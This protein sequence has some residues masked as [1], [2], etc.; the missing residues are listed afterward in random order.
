MRSKGYSLR[1]DCLLYAEKPFNRILALASISGKGVETVSKSRDTL[2]SLLWSSKFL[3]SFFLFFQISNSAAQNPYLALPVVLGSSGSWNSLSFANISYTIGEPSIKTI[4]GNTRIFSQ[5]FHQPDPGS[6][7]EICAVYIPNAFTPFNGHVNDTFLIPSVHNVKAEAMFYTSTQ[8]ARKNNWTIESVPYHQSY[9]SPV[10]VGQVMSYEDTD[11]SVF[12]SN[13]GNQRSVPTAAAMG[14]GKHVAE[15]GSI[16]RMDETLG[17]VVLE[18][19]TGTAVDGEQFYA[20]RTAQMVAGIDQANAIN[21]YPQFVNQLSGINCGVC[22][23]SGMFDNDGSWATFYNQNNHFVNK[24]ARF[25]LLEDQI[26]DAERAHRPEQVSYVLFGTI[27]PK[28][29][30]EGIPNEVE[31]ESYD[32]LEI[33]PTV[34]LYP[35]PASAEVTISINNETSSTAMFTLTNMM[36]QVISMEEVN[37]S[38]ASHLHTMDVS[39]LAEGVYMLTYD[40]GTFKSTIRFVKH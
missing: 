8:T 27:T 18:M 2:H 5:G 23:Q 21:G 37:L 1:P 17:Y 28:S 35:N 36:G 29:D 9:T 4:E 3:L 16:A 33:R 14:I 24:V 40:N 20:G 7:G 19:G 6:G 10:V 11:W 39:Y 13:G 30:E 15:D 38:G 32:E 34:I 31:F 26:G 12:W 22:A 25:V